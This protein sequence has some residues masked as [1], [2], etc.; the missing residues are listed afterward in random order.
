MRHENMYFLIGNGCVSN[1]QN[2]FRKMSRALAFTV[3]AWPCGAWAAGPAPVNLGYA[4]PYVILSKTGI[5]DVPGS[6]VTGRV[7]TSPIT[8]AADHLACAEVTGL[9][10]SVDAAGPK[11]CGYKK[12]ATLAVAVLNMGT[13][14]TDAAGRAPDVTELGAGNIGGMTLRPGVYKWSSGVLIPAN[15]TLRG[16]STDTWIFQIARNLRI[17]SGV[18]VVLKGGARAKNIVWQVAGQTTIETTASF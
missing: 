5:T 6:V 7:G 18:S 12:P 13:A 14:Y 2:S 9:I 8:G 10:F 4:V 16:T 1:N 11:P 17:D 15:V 3:L